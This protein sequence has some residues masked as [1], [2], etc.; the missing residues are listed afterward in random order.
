MKGQPDGMLRRSCTRKTGVVCAVQDWEAEHIEKRWKW[1]VSSGGGRP[2]P[3]IA[4]NPA[5]R[6]IPRGAVAG[7]TT[8]CFLC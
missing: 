1:Q 5:S 7:T 3:L 4:S 8:C 2:L 6:H